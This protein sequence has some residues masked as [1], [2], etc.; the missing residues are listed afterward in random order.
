ML[1]W[2]RS[3][4][5]FED[6]INPRREGANISSS[7]STTNILSLVM[8]VFGVAYNFTFDQVDDLFGD[9]GGMVRKTLQMA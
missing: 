4:G 9:V 8:L 7:S 3:H 2:K 1:V 5:N 6:W